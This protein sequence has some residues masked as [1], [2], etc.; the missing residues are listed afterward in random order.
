MLR[1]SPK[2]STAKP[3]KATG[4][5]FQFFGVQDTVLPSLADNPGIWFH[6][7]LPQSVPLRRM[8]GV[9]K[10]LAVV[11]ATFNTKQ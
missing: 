10:V 3:S 5:L 7:V 1:L 6:Q 11:L 8:S 2:I 9:W 4:E